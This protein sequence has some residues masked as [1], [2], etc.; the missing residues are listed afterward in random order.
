MDKS[1]TTRLHRFAAARFSPGEAFGLH[2]TVGVLALLLA[3]AGFARIA[4]AVVA[5]APITQLDVEL[6][7]W[8]HAHAHGN[9]VLRSFLMAVTQLHSTPGVL[10]LT[11]LAGWWLVRRGARHWMLTLLVTVPGGMVLNVL[12]KHT[13]E[14]ARPHFDE[15]I[16]TLTT[17]SFPSGHT[18]AA[19][20]LYGL[21]ACYLTRHAQRWSA[22][23]GWILL[24]CLM[25][26]L[27]AGSRLYL[28]AH[29]LS[30]VL[31]AMAEGCAWLSICVTGVATLRRR[32]A[33][34]ARRAT[35]NLSEKS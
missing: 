5:G 28:G 24:A 19:T 32:Q 14:R 4:G 27:V 3:M 22:R 33:A 7:N 21:L 30:D 1:L 25:V 35:I 16:L 2:L 31:A 29:Y 11:A 9:A 17:Y 34:R 20:L 26:A 6:A 8:L 23:A 18:V 12:M 13:F 10:A 15:P